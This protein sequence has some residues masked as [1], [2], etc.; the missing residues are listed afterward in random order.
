MQ[1][2]T[3]TDNFAQQRQDAEDMHARR[4]VC[5]Y[6]SLVPRLQCPALLACGE[7]RAG[8]LVHVHV[9]MYVTRCRVHAGVGWFC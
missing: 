4:S 3:H 6:S 8:S 7:T 9:Y 1:A 2:H 5:V